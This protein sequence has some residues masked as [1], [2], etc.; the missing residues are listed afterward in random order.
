MYVVRILLKSIILVNS[1][2]IHSV[3]IY[4]TYYTYYNTRTI[5]TIYI[6]YNRCTGFTPGSVANPQDEWVYSKPLQVLHIN[7]LREYLRAEFRALESL[8]LR[9]FY[10]FERVVDDFVF[11]CF[12]VGKLSYIWDIY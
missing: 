6:L 2:F 8:N 5:N 10:D 3:P 1:A 12:F 11:M 4:L 7:I 9:V